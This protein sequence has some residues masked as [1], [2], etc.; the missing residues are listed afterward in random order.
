MI[1]N[2]LWCDYKS[3][4]FFWFRIYG[5][6]L[7]FK[8]IRKHPLLFSERNGYTKTINI[9]NWSIKFLTNGNN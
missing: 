2:R 8:D 4:G 7:C 6:G 3:E 1:A 5:Y 9:N